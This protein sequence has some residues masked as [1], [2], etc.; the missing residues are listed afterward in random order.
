MIL[1]RVFEDKPTGYYVDVGAHHP[2][3]FSNTYFFYKRGWSGINID[4]MPGSMKLFEQHRARD[5]NIELGVGKKR[6]LLNYHIFNEPALNGFSQALSEERDVAESQNCLLEIKKIEVRPLAEIL[7]DHLPAHQGIDFLTID[8]EGLDL[9]VL[10][11]NNWE[12]YRPEYVL[13]EV[14]NNNFDALANHPISKFM[15]EQNYALFAKCTN[16]VFFVRIE[17]P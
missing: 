11:S 10:S 1:R 4:A 12:K 3:R 17:M 13:V 15:Q 9:E 5:T 6:A 14:L 16:T 7:D 2:K 8:V